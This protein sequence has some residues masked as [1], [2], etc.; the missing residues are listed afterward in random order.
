MRNRRPTRRRAR[1]RACRPEVATPESNAFAIGPF[2]A[3]RRVA[4]RGPRAAPRGLA[5]R[6]RALARP[7]TLPVARPLALGLAMEDRLRRVPPGLSVNARLSRPKSSSSSSDPS[8]RRPFLLG[9]FL[10]AGAGPAFAA[11][12]LHW[13]LAQSWK[14]QRS[15]TAGPPGACVGTSGPTAVEESLPGRATA[16]R[17]PRKSAHAVWHGR[18]EGQRAVEAHGL[19]VPGPPHMRQ[20]Q[21]PAPCS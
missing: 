4:L 21:E 2:D 8:S 15:R 6:A 12:W 3:W 9:L 11:S 20:T 7:L 19:C 18:V 14:Q 10:F 13:G 17:P 16:R 1:P 5:P